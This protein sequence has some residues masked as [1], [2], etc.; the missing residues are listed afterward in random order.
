MASPPGKETP[1]QLQ[2]GY[3]AL[4]ISDADA[5]SAFRMC[6]IVCEAPDPVA[7]AFVLLRDTLEASVYLGCLVDS[8]GYVHDWIELWIQNIS[9]LETTLDAYR[10]TFSN[11]SL[12]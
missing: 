11:R 8:G 1:G 6:V 5:K 3:R 10:E 12:D 4:A 7:G 2:K 9:S